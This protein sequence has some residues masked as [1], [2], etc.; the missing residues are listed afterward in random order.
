VLFSYFQSQLNTLQRAVDDSACTLS[1]LDL[2]IDIETTLDE[3]QEDVTVISEVFNEIVGKSPSLIILSLEV[4]VR[5]PVECVLVRANLIPF[6]G[7]PAAMPSLWR[8]C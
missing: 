4:A 1:N 2:Q 8:R 3:M 7:S 5:P 6:P